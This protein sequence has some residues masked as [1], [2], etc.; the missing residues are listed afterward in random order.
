[1]LKRRLRKWI[2]TPGKLRQH[3]SLKMFGSWMEET[4]LWQL[5]RTTTAR[6]FAI[7]LY[8]AMLPVPGQMIIS[9][10]LAIVFSAN[11]PL[12]FSL[13]FIT[14][15][16]TMPAIY[17]AAYKLGAWILGTEPLD[18]EF[19]ASWT[20]F[21]QSL[22]EIWIPLLVG[23]QVMG[24]VCAVL[25]YWLIDTMWRNA[26]RRQWKARQKKRG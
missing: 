14:N 7:G 3:R 19:E 21:T 1:M 10:A 2:P 9:T 5:S 16:L 6:A 17:F 20:W 8:C 25:G 11:I 26:I 15:P 22:D 23:S 24:L 18:V 4:H 12:S 13:I